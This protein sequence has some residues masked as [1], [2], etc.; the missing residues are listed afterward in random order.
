M[1]FSNN[2]ELPFKYLKVLD[3]SSVLAGPLTGSFFAELGANVIKVENKNTGGDATRQWKLPSENPESPYSAYYHSA[4]FGKEEVLLNLTLD[5]DRSRLEKMISQSDVVIS[6]FQ[7]KVATKFDLLPD[8]LRSRYPSLIIAQLSAYD[9]D[10]PRPGY[11]LVMQGETGWI[12]M[13]GTDKDHYAKLP[14]AMIDIIA[15]HQMKEA[16]LISLLKK[17]TTGKGSVVHVSLYK[18]ALSALVNQATNYLIAGKIPTPTGTLHP[19]IAP[20]GDVFEDKI[21]TKFLLAIGS[22]AQF[23]KLWFTLNLSEEEYLTFE[24]NCG[25]LEQRALLQGTLQ[26][27]FERF[28][29]SELQLIFNQQNI[30]Y[31]E[32]KSLDTV[33][34]EKESKVMLN[35]EIMDGEIVTSVSNIAFTY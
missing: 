6:N 20:Y 15:S 3:L 19:N 27:S 12:S 24:F 17:A 31:C 8:D 11:D 30:P 18:S 21:G 2:M 28:K 4:N 35:H 5:E 25:R 32:I 10:D 7:K 33:F 1:N 16:I 26:Q 29:I 34:A 14:V 23:K 22:D 13:T 9:F